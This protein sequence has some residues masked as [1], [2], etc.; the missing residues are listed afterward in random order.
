MHTFEPMKFLSFNYCYIGVFLVGIS[1]TQVGILNIDNMHGM[2]F[3]P[4]GGLM[5]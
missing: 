4:K 2:S 5:D 3:Y 1:L